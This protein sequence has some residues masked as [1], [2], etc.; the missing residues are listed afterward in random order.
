MIRISTT[1]ESVA[2]KATMPSDRPCSGIGRSQASTS[3]GQ[4]N[5]VHDYN[6]GTCMIATG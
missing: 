4:E 2:Y 6:S 3:N 5:G 1:L